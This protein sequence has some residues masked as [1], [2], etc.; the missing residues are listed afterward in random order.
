MRSLNNK[1]LFK[2]S[3]ILFKILFETITLILSELPPI[4]YLLYYI[5]Y[6]LFHCFYQDDYAECH[7][8]ECL[9]AAC[10]GALHSH[11][12]LLPISINLHV[13]HLLLSC[14]PG[15]S[16]VQLYETYIYKHIRK[17]VYIYIYICVCVCVCVC[18]CVCV[19]LHITLY[20]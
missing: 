10:H 6:I 2:I 17:Y 5:K 1:K 8:A 12:P 7:Y 16:T 20:T 11:F 3:R 19:T 4:S 15:A 9:S 14:C 13:E 18:L